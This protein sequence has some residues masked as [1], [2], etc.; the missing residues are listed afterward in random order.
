ME[1]WRKI[2]NY[3][4]YECSNTGHIKTFNWKR[5]GQ[6]RIMKPALD[7]KGYL[8][9]VLIDDNGKYCTV[10]VHRIVAQTWI[11][12][13]YNK[14]QV[15]HLNGIKNDNRAE[16][17]E[18]CTNEE[19]SLHRDENNLQIYKRGSEVGTS[20]LTESEVREIRQRFKPN[21]CTRKMLA[22]EYGVAPATIKGIV[23][24][25]TWKHVE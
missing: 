3:S 6:T 7:N 20:I 4:L 15:N 22:E 10:K 23:L 24:R 11:E 19:N 5:S 12:N 16:N 25:R 18:W 17:L 13:T 8:R 14:P 9:T 2:P 1:E 21:I